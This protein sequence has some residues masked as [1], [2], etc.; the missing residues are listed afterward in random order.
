MLVLM[1]DKNINVQVEAIKGITKLIQT[2]KIRKTLIEGGLIDKVKELGKHE[3]IKGAGM[4]TAIVQALRGLIVQIKVATQSA[5][6]PPPAKKPAETVWIK[7]RL[8]TYAKMA[9]AQVGDSLESFLNTVKNTY[10]LNKVQLAFVHGGD[11]MVLQTNADFDFVLEQNKN[12]KKIEVIVREIPDIVAPVQTIPQV[13]A[14]GST[15]L[16]KA[17]MDIQQ[18]ELANS[19]FKP[20]VVIP[21]DPP[22]PLPVSQ[23]L[24]IILRP[25]R[26]D[27][28]WCICYLASKVLFTLHKNNKLHKGIRQECLIIT[29]EGDL[30]LEDGPFL[31]DRFLAPETNEPSKC[32]T[33]S[34]VY[35]LGACLWTC[36]D[37]LMEDDEEPNL[38]QELLFVIEQMTDDDPK[39]RPNIEFIL[40]ESMKYENSATTV[41]RELMKEVERKKVLKRDLQAKNVEKQ[42]ALSKNLLGEIRSGIQ[43]KQ[44]T[45]SE[46]KPKPNGGKSLLFEIE[47][48]VKTGTLRHVEPPKTTRTF[49]RHRG[50]FLADIES[51][52][53]KRNIV[54][55]EQTY[56]EGMKL[57]AR[58]VGK[59]NEEIQKVF[60]WN[61]NMVRIVFRLIEIIDD[62][63]NFEDYVRILLIPKGQ[64][65]SEFLASSHPK[66]PTLPSHSPS[67]S[68]TLPSPPSPSP[69][70]H[71]PST[72]PRNQTPLYQIGQNRGSPPTSAKSPPSSNPIS[73]TISSPAFNRPNPANPS[74]SS[75]S[76][77]PSSIPSALVRNPSTTQLQAAASPGLA[78]RTA[79]NAKPPAT[80]QNA[81]LPATNL[82]SKIPAISSIAKIQGPAEGGQISPRAKIGIKPESPR[83]SLDPNARILLGN[84]NPSMISVIE[85]IP[86]QIDESVEERFANALTRIGFSLKF[87]KYANE[88]R[89]HKEYLD[90]FRP[91]DLPLATFCKAILICLKAVHLVNWRSSGN[92]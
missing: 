18:A 65:L 59:W 62:R 28:I 87:N 20:Q 77:F 27:E 81:K 2:V 32:T 49:K 30:I 38:S 45:I 78:L 82:N 50:T 43:L 25:L 3:N 54:I 83:S 40:Q 91:E 73:R 74:L 29:L 46:E 60:L 70:F 52:S 63:V 13:P 51:E 86:T 7:C 68:P 21:I 67:S 42:V 79:P 36:A 72:S 35:G 14:N 24:D 44:V 90:I 10:N 22:K 4:E 66:S 80:S 55:V 88:I 16:V 92:F 8:G 23:I 71:S 1:N 85:N 57:W 53:A 19:T 37:F 31:L 33:K 41:M 69:T 26:E 47:N 48:A 76:P 17:Y 15:K 56:V 75:P 11:E 84:R 34:D 64:K 58:D 6:A 61:K 39:E 89:E 9:K 12:D 5:S